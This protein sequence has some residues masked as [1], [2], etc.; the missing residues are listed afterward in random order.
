MPT[1][2]ETGEHGFIRAIRERFPMALA[3]DDGAVLNRLE[4]PV[5]TTDSFF[6]GTHFHRWWTSPQ[7]LAARLLEAALSDLA[8]MG[9]FPRYLFSSIVLPPEMEL[10]WIVGFYEGLTGRQDCPVAGGETVRG[11]T[12]GITLTAIG[13]CGSEQPLLRSN[14]K[15]GDSV[16]VTGPLGRSFNSPEL[17]EK[18]RKEKLTETEMNQIELFLTPGARFDAV[19]LLRNAGSTTAIDISD[20]LFSECGHISQESKVKVIVQLERVPLVSFC[21]N[22]PFEACSAGEDFE[23]LFTIPENAEAA[24]CHRIG[25]IEKGEGTAVFL[26]GKAIDIRTAGYDHFH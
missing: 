24:G 18:S 11:K 9:A 12:F 3:G 26:N 10:N 5:V 23:L 7:R 4:K 14:A 13:D 19:P 1:L 22:N 25:F 21:E 17:L 20:G 2:K 6:E 16:W 15:P 8:A